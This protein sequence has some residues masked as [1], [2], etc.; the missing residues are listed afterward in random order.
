[1]NGS[2]KTRQRTFSSKSRKRI[3]EI[4]AKAIIKDSRNGVSCGS[5]V[6]YQFA[7]ECLFEYFLADT[8]VAMVMPLA[9]LL[10]HSLG[11]NT[12]V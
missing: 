6:Q 7:V 1:M 2:T 8:F 10:S 3:D 4:Q 9:Y 5:A 11:N 12:L